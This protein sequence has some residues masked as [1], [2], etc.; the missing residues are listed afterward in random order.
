MTERS[1]IWDVGGSVPP[2]SWAIP[3]RPH[4]VGLHVLLGNTKAAPPCSHSADG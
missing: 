4:P 1:W 2:R 3:G